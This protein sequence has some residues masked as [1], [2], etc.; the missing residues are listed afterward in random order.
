MITVVVAAVVMLVIGTLL[1]TSSHS[2]DRT[3]QNLE[4][5]QT[6][7]ATMDFMSRDIRSAGYGADLD[8]VTPQPSIAY[9]DSMQIILS[10]NQMPYPDTTGGVHAGPQAYNPAGSPNPRPL[11]GTQW[12]PPG[13]YTTGAELIR[14][15]L[16]LNNDGVVDASD[17]ATA[18]G[19]DAQ[20]SKNPNDYVLVRQVYGDNT[21]GVANNNGG[22]QERVA[23]VLKPGGSVPPLFT[24]Y[25]QGSTT[26]YDW[27][28][29]PV[30][31]N[32]L[33]NID[34]VKVQVTTSSANPDSRGNYP[35]TTLRTEIN[36]FR[37]VPNTGPAK[38]TVS[39]YVYN[40]LNTNH[41]KD[42]SDTGILGATVQMGSMI[43]YTNAAGYYSFS[44]PAGNYV[45]SQ[46][47][48]Q[49]FGIFTQPDTFAVTLGGS[50]LTYSFADT[51]RHGG[52][53]TINVYND[54]NSN[55]FFDTGESY[56]S[57]V[58]VALGG[59][60]GYTDSYGN[61]QLFAAPGV[62]SAMAT[63]PDSMAATTA[64]PVT[65]SIADGG[66][67]NGSI[68]LKV[69]YTGKVTGTVFTDLNKNGVQ[70]AGEAGIPN[71]W[72]GLTKD[73]GLNV[74]G[75]A[76]TD[77][78]GNY[79][80]TVPINDPPHTNAYTVYVVPPANYF[81]TG[82]T[83]IGNIWL[84]ANQTISGKLFGMANFQ[85]IT[86]NAQRVLSLAAGNLMEKDWKANKTDQAVG[87]NDLVLGAD[88]AGT[89]QIS[90]WFNQYNSS[91]LFNSSPDYTRSAPQSVLCMA[92][93]TLDV[94]I[95]PFARPDLV[96][97]TKLSPSGNFF[98]WYTQNSS[99]NEGY[100]PSTFSPS[101]NYKTLDNGDV[102]AVL[103]L[104]LL[105]GNKPD[106]IVGTKSSTANQGSIE[107]WT[108]SNANTPTF[109]RAE[110]YTLIPPST[111][112]G[113]VDGMALGD[114]DGDGLPDLV[115]A[116]K[117]G[118]YSGQL[119]FFKN[120]G[121]SAVGNHFQYMTSAVLINKAA[122]ALAVDDV[123]G[124]GLVDVIVG[125]QDGTS[126]GSLLF[127]KNLGLWSFTRKKTQSA[128]GIVLST[129]MADEGGG[130]SIKDLVVGYRNNT[131][132]FAGGVSIYYL[133]VLGL[134]NTGTDPSGG[135][136]LYMVPAIAAAN[137]NYGVYPVGSAPTP[138]LTDLAVGVKQT[139]TAGSLVIFIR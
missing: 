122:T 67:A 24:V 25:M 70:D 40:D 107:V 118:S 130:A 31:A 34:R 102:Q 6:G 133:D 21:G 131:S 86:V 134:P 100:F 56:L 11:V 81:P 27:S 22:V 58:K 60:S 80:I 3:A 45:L 110:T 23:L 17:R 139:A 57:G 135:S 66:T 138:Y 98:V 103:T 84:Q 90:V 9:I 18:A 5:T 76:T 119:I 42:G 74:D 15:T 93:D 89:D 109:T 37:N 129:V 52:M 28:N 30:P 46:V 33:Q 108:N 136:I 94:N 44:A 65:G 99:G 63:V 105:G 29:G 69:A 96:T 54:V 38:Y 116:T 115:V 43:R 13:K 132:S 71:V 111:P 36:S 97:G 68:G 88:A 126:S 64:N 55:G 104:D 114:L 72:V 79:T 82:S 14:Y 61:V 128:P 123:D 95:A 12:T 127:Y 92:L 117:T 124:D 51:A 41:I 101:Q 137:F 53:V 16:D 35:Q 77:A 20:A 8:N 121:K 87:D 106:I 83:A 1:L 19:A 78:S 50:N 32:Q 59:Y 112:I 113:E 75:Y 73:G 7:R 47:P 125:T 39:G 48:P 62:W 85:V 120:M 4:A 49:G 2:K 10:E 26:P 91:P